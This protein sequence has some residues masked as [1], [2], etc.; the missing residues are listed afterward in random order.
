MQC[1]HFEEV[2]KGELESLVK[3]AVESL[4]CNNRDMKEPS[5]VS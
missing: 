1:L 4:M 2:V 5:A 3:E